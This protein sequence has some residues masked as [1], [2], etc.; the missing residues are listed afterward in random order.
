MVEK[1]S[2]STR[3]TISV[4]RDLK[5]RMDKVTEDVN[6]SAIACQ[7]FEQKLGEIASKK[8]KKE[9]NDVI[10]RLRASKIESDNQCY[11]SGYAEGQDWAANIAAADEL[12]RLKRLK[13]QCSGNDWHTIFS[14]TGQWDP[15][16]LSNAIAP[17]TK[18]TKFAF[19]EFWEMC[20][21][22]NSERIWEPEFAKGFADGAID[23]WSKVKDQ[24]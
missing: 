16:F 2:G 18:D 8:E 13:E 20:L 22:D 6:W 14:A 23:V 7:A 5:R 15:S 4:P 21:G 11:A 17:D 1:R 3:T 24:L 9:M 10:Q 19:D 12:H